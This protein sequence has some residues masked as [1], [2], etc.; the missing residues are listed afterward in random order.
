[1]FAFGETAKSEDILRGNVPD[2]NVPAP[3]GDVSR[4]IETFNDATK[5][6]RNLFGGEQP[7]IR[8]R[9]QRAQ[10]GVLHLAETQGLCQRVDGRRG[11]ADGAPLLK[12]DVPIDTNTRELSQF[13]PS[14]TRRSTASDRWK[15]DGFRCQAVPAGSQ[16]V[17]QLLV[18]RS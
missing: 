6:R 3:A 14:K 10:M 11:R 9:R 18:P 7:T 12:A 17:R 8:R 16:K 1:V 15:A 13:L 5:R 4:L 2:Q